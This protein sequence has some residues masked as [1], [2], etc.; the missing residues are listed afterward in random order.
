MLSDNN[1]WTL[2]HEYINS[3]R[4]HNEHLFDWLLKNLSRKVILV[5]AVGVWESDIT[6]KKKAKGQCPW[7]YSPLGPGKCLGS[8]M[9][10]T[11]G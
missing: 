8:K 4:I 5:Y 10:K 1:L 2:G 6:S 3:T 11:K 9:S 7:P